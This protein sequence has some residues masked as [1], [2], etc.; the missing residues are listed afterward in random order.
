MSLSQSQVEKDLIQRPDD[1]VTE[2]GLY[3]RLQ[4]FDAY[5][6]LGGR[7]GLREVMGVKWHRVLEL[8]RGVSV[9]DDSR[10]DS[11]FFWKDFLFPK[12]SA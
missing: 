12:T 9:P 5:N 11:V 2:K 4:S 6:E 1:P 7:K 10:G 3:A 8:T